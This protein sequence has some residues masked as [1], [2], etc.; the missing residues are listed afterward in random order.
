MTDLW[1]NI[2]FSFTSV[3]DIL[4]VAIF[5]YYILY[6][7]KGTRSARIASGIVFLIL[8]YF[9]SDR[10]QLQ[11]MSWILQNFFGYIMIAVIVIFQADIRK[12]LATFGRNPFLDFLR[13]HE[14]PAGYMSE[15]QRGVTLLARSNTGALIV[16]ERDIEMRNLIETGVRLNADIRSELLLSIFNTRSPIHDGAVIISNGRLAA[17]AIILPLSTRADI[18]KEYGTRHRAA[19]GM[20]EECDAVVIVVSEERGVVSL[21]VDGI[22]TELDTPLE[23]ERRISAILKA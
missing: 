13:I 5:V 22:I 4:L 1:Q 8:L 12:A 10:F 2:N 7:L 21:A 15:L 11:T 14:K 20:S 16:I 23:L 19:I 3:V 18:D 9:V 17:A 6:P